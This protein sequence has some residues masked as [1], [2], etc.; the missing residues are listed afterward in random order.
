MIDYYPRLIPGNY[1]HIFNRA[2]GDDKLF[3]KK[4]NYLFFL[5][6]FQYY[7]SPYLETYAYCLLQNH[8]H[9]LVRLFEEEQTK[10]LP[11]TGRTLHSKQELRQKREILYRARN[12]E[13]FTVSHPQQTLIVDP[14]EI[15]SE[16]FRR[17]FVSYS[18][19]INVSENRVGSLF[20]KN[21][22]RLKIDS[23]RHF[24]NVVYYIHHNPSHYGYDIADIDYPW[25]SYYSFLTEKPT[26]LKRQEVLGWFGGK[27]EFHKF[28]LKKQNLNTI[29]HLIIE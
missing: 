21:F 15:I 27:D 14:S 10:H 9:F 7:L 2:N 26:K 1:Y 17:L 8:F 20:R 19:S 22:K 25:S 6:R 28:H 29:N 16:Q 23:Y 18:K 3:Y 11:I 24:M 13:P 12:S 5:R 4:E